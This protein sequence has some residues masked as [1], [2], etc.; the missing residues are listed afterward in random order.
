MIARD[1]GVQ[2]LPHTLDLVVV[3]AIGRQEVQDDLPGEVPKRRL[4]DR[5]VVNRVNPFSS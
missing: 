1:L 2:I 3:G 4:G 5:A